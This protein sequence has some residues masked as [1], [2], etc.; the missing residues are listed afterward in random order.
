MHTLSVENRLITILGYM[1]LEL[2]RLTLASPNIITIGS[3]ENTRMFDIRNFEEQD[4]DSSK[5]PSPPNV[6]CIFLVF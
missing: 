3:Y 5:H 1:N 4:A 2:L 6:E